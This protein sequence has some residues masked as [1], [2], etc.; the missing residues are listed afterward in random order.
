MGLCAVSLH[1]VLAWQQLHGIAL[2]PDEIEWL[3][4]MDAAVLA[5]LAE[6]E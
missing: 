5:C 6:T 3:F 4:D 2:R 1:D